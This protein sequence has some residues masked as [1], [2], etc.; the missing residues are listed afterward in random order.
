MK[1]SPI[2]YFNSNN[3]T[4]MFAY[5]EFASIELSKGIDQV[6]AFIDEHK[7]NYLIG[8][9]SYDVKNEIFD[10]QSMN[11]D[12]INFPSLLFWKP[13]V[14]YSI[15]EKG[16]HQVQG[17]RSKEAE[18]TLA[19]FLA[20]EQE[21]C[22]PLGSV[23][24]A[25]ISKDEYLE[26]INKIQEQ[27]QYGNS[28]EV[29]FCQTFLAENCAIEDP[30]QLYFK[31][32]AITKAPFSVYLSWNEFNVLCGSPER[33]IQKKGNQ[34][35]SQPIKGTAPRHTNEQLD[36]ELIN[37]LQTSS[38]ERAENTMIVDLVRNDLARIAQKDSVEVTE[39]C[40]VH[41]FATVHQL[42]STVTCELKENTT[43]TDCLKATFPMGSMTGAPKLRTMEIIEELENFQ[44]GLYSGS[45]GY[46]APN[47]DFDFNVVIRSLL[48]NQTLKTASLSVGGAITIQSNPE[49]EY[50]ECLVKIQR[51]MDGLNE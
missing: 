19:E 3:G 20:K 39:F 12:A 2:A 22:V 1:A 42:I 45:I 41:S 36:K 14:V 27:I 4:G 5:G 50:E 9:V 51:I 11:N 15:T 46:I 18:V 25:T 35:R 37:T 6:Q 33:Y 43:F 38:K 8:C 48:Y 49:E 21:K 32:N 17:N 26:K 34:L 28:Y 7:G 30:E 29:N 13:L 31:L 47:G 40:G 16:I 23:F 44:R 10:L 24:Q